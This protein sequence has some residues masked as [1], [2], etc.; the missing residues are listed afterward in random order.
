MGGAAE[1]RASERGDHRDNDG[2]VEGERDAKRARSDWPLVT[3]ALPAVRIHADLAFLMGCDGFL[4]EGEGRLA[5]LAKAL[6]EA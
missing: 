3:F 4:A 2:H 5:R 1:E 6:A